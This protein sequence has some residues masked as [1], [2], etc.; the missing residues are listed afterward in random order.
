MMRGAFA[1]VLL[2]LVPG[3]AGGESLGAVAQKEKERRKQNEQAGVKSRV[4][5]E[6]DLKSNKG[7]LANDPNQAKPAPVATAAKGGPSLLGAEPP[8]AGGPDRAQQEAGWRARMAQARARLDEAKKDYE[9]LSGQYLTRGESFV[10]AQ[11]RTVV[12]SP[13]HLQMLVKRAKDAVDAAQMALDS[14]EESAR[15]QGVPPGW[16]R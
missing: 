10:D 4:V 12:A 1:L 6:E 8:R 16:L 11:G 15:R 5:T 13:E 14:L 2:S 9:Y 3:L 7:Q